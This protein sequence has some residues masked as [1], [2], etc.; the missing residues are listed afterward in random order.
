M[1]AGMIAGVIVWLFALW[2]YKAGD[3]WFER[4]AK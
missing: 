2:L 3:A 4:R 1:I